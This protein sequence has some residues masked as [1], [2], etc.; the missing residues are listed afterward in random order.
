MKEYRVWK[1]PFLEISH[2]DVFF[3]GCQ[4]EIL[5]EARE[6]NESRGREA[7]QRGT[8]GRLMMVMVLIMMT[9]MMMMIWKNTKQMVSLVFGQRGSMV[10]TEPS[11]SFIDTL[12]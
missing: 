5:Q 1:P 3:A 6:K 10:Q 7:L 8:H 9:M 2:K 12:T 4:A 11:P